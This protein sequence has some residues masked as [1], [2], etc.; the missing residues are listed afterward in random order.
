V[1]V[2]AAAG[3]DSAAGTFG[4]P[5]RSFAK[6][7][8]L[9]R[10]ANTKILFRRG[11]AW[12][13][14]AVMAITAANVH[15]GA[16]GTGANPVINIT[17]QK[18]AV[19]T[20]SGASH[21]VI[22]GL[23][24]D[25]PHKPV[26]QV[27]NKTGVSAIFTGGTGIAVRDCTFLNVDDAVNANQNPN[28]LIVMD[29]DAPSVTGLR[30][31][32]LWAQGTDVVAVGNYAANSTREHIIR[33]ADA[34]RLLVAYNDFAN[35]KRPGLDGADIDK[36]T[37][38][39]QRGSW[40]YIYGNTTRDG[41]VRVGPRGEATEPSSTRTNVAVIAN[42]RI[43]NYQVN[44]N[45][46]THHLAIREQPDHGER[47]RRHPDHA[48]RPAGPERVEHLHLRQR[49][50]Q[51]RVAGPVPAGRGRDGRPVGHPG[52]NRYVAPNLAVGGNDTVA[53]SVNASDL[54][55]FKAI[56]GNVWAGAEVD[57]DLR[58]GRA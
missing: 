56:Y 10:S 18:V 6:A 25:T 16:Y 39:M 52:R 2:D 40:A 41:P 11:Q 15:V 9:A 31:Y 29:N 57:L 35:P 13:T 37:I 54:S 7:A 33:A 1:Y 4:A 48:V 26:G 44:V 28:G 19:Q 36:G 22:E 5:I 32:L 14:N 24:F 42:N 58:P 55:G 46:G 45:P 43:S 53:V 17:G 12:N 21:V 3:N 20:F 47:E 30:A 27:A 34:N 23:T 50:V 38:E 51:Q 8:A 49:R